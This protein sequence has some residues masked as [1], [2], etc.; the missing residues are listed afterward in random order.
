MTITLEEET[1]IFIS[2]ITTHGVGPIVHTSPSTTIHSTA[3][4]IGTGITLTTGT[5]HTT[6]GVGMTTDGI[7]HITTIITI[8]TTTTTTHITHIMVAE[9]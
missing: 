6:H 5:V 8:T 2:T 4:S 7:I 3:H 9:A 1:P